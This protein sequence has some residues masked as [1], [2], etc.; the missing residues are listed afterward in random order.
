MLRATFIV[1]SYTQVRFLVNKPP[2]I[3]R[4]HRQNNLMIK[5]VRKNNQNKDIFLS[6]YLAHLQHTKYHRRNSKCFIFIQTIKNNVYKT[7][8]MRTK[9]DI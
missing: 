7:H 6:I 2:F 8:N 9:Y 4:I 3:Y 5:T 1:I